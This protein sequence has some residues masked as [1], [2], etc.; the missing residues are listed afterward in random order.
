MKTKLIILMSSLLISVISYSQVPN[1]L[2]AKNAGGTNGDYVQGCATDANG[3]VFITGY[4][5]SPAISFGS[6]TLT[7]AGGGDMFIVKYDANG[8][9]QW[10]KRAGEANGYEA[11][12]GIAVTNTGSVMVTGSF[13]S[14]YVTFG[15]VTL[16]N[17]VPGGTSDM[18]VVRYDA[19]GN[20]Q[21]A[22]RAGSYGS[23]TGYSCAVDQNGN[24]Y[25]V[26]Q[27]DSPNITFGSF[28]L[29]NSAGIDMYY[30]IFIAKYDAG[31]AV[32]WAK[33]AG[34]YLHDGARGCS[35]D[36]NGNL[37]VTGHFNNSWITFGSDT[38]YNSDANNN[39]EI[40]L[41]K[42][43][44]A[45]NVLWAKSAGGSKFDFSYG[46]AADLNG[47]VFITGAFQSDS[48]T[49][50]SSVLY[51]SG[52]SC[53]AGCSDMYVAKYDAGGNLLWAK[54]SGGNNSD[55]GQSCATD[56]NGNLLV[57][58]Y[59]IS[60]SI[61]FGSHTLNN[62]LSGSR[63][64]FITKYDVSGNSLWAFRAGGNNDEWGYGCT[65][66]VNNNIIL[67]GTFAS[68]S[69][70]FG[71]FSFTNAGGVNCPG[72]PCP[73]IFLVKLAS[74]TGLPDI[75]FNQNINLFPNPSSG[76]IQLLIPENINPSQIEVYNTLGE[77]IMQH[78]ASPSSGTITL[79]LQTAPSGIYFVKLI[80]RQSHSPGDNVVSVQKVVVNKE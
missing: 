45:G 55:L 75:T 70:A 4:F 63:D 60:P 11:G 14:S 12:Y 48:I 62:S 43:S 69:I 28:N 10:A 73:D 26:G 74:T 16:T 61:S 23:E 49:F 2:W 67:T 54:S 77:K 44:S 53:P 50:D 40:F 52:G 80:G 39:Y 72:G 15:S 36:L 59:F 3:N 64:V 20:V 66:D 34:E 42:Y 57:T 79:D 21:W 13:S 27:F 24:I 18:F 51:N 76:I 33:Q 25:V 8:N 32:L 9:V 6:I 1:Y 19:N 30:D 29:G 7:N 22:K 41:V 35:T 46:C 71:P 47:N 68:S 78:D 58:G 17:A 38:I 65:A 5:S 56:A 31:G 37:F